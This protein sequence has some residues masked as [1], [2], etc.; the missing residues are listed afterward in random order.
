LFVSG[1]PT[2]VAKF[3][4]HFDHIVLLSAP[5]PVIVGRLAARTDNLYGK[6]PHEVARVLSLKKEVEPRLRTVAGYEID[7]AAPLKEV[8]ETLLR[9]VR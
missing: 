8:V 2:N 6:Q 1:C 5:T 7:T 3:F 9:L 4:P